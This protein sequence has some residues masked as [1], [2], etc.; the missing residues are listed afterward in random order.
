M[1]G[2][3]LPAPATGTIPVTVCNQIK[4][5]TIV[6]LFFLEVLICLALICISPPSQEVARCG[7]RTKPCTLSSVF[8]A[9][10]SKSLS[11]SA[12]WEW[13]NSAGNWTFTCAPRRA[14]EPTPGRSRPTGSSKANFFFSLTLSHSFTVRSNQTLK[15]SIKN[16]VTARFHHAKTSKSTTLLPVLF[17]LCSRLA[18][19]AWLSAPAKIRRRKKERQ[20]RE[21][22]NW[23][24]SK[25]R[26]HPDTVSSGI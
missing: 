4:G 19:L 23:N 6:S 20:K 1:Q 7:G 8:L 10:P 2:C 3:T 15:S 12:R 22:S 16:I 9:W 13:E 26:H 18:R 5:T 17:F 24:I 21:V 14:A 25:S 11:L